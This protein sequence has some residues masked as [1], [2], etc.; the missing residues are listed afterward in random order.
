MREIALF[1][2]SLSCRGNPVQFNT[3]V[4]DISGRKIIG[5]KSGVTM[6]EFLQVRREVLSKRLAMAECKKMP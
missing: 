5:I 2:F 6:V 3:L 4:A 1:F